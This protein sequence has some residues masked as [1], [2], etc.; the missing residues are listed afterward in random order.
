M[1]PDRGPLPSL[2]QALDQLHATEH[3]YPPEARIAQTRAALTA[4]ERLCRDRSRVDAYF[5]YLG[6][7]D[8]FQPIYGMGH[9][10]HGL[11]VSL[12]Q[13]LMELL[14]AS[15]R[16]LLAFMRREVR[17]QG[18]QYLLERAPQGWLSDQMAARL[19][20]YYLATEPDLA[21]DVLVYGV[22]SRRGVT[23]DEMLRGDDWLH[24]KILE[25]QSCDT[26]YGWWREYLKASRL[27]GLGDG[28][29]FTLDTDAAGRPLDDAALDVQTLAALNHP[30][31]DDPSGIVFIEV[32]PEKQASGQNLV[33]MAD[34]MGGGD[35]RRRPVVLD[36][37]DLEIRDGRVFATKAGCEREIRKGI[38]RIVDVDLTAYVHAREADGQ[39]EVI[40]RFKRIYDAPHVWGD[41]SKH[42]MGFYLINKTT[43]TRLSDLGMSVVARTESLTPERVEAIRREPGRLE[44][45]AIKPLLG[46][47]AKGVIVQPT[48][49][50]LTQAVAHEPMLMQELFHATPVLP[51]INP[52][53]ADPDVRAGVCCEARLLTHGGSPAVAH[54]PHRA[55]TVGGLSRSHYQSA[56]PRRRIKNDRAGRGWYSNMGAILAVK[57]ELGLTSKTDAGVGM[58]PIYWLD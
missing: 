48:L 2:E 44:T 33:F 52:D 43:L 7:R 29:R 56:D 11:P 58:A 32:D 13:Y 10:P 37:R 41:L 17:E 47:S 39:G 15:A 24:A 51:D 23:F 38:S 57:G 12:P 18:P 28:C 22:N 49:T 42:L 19:H 36:P 16:V 50:E 25:A 21:F 3:K 5:G 1:T 14:D 20:D 53:I 45:I 31:A 30:C 55:R 34:A 40:E 9:F 26:Y 54:N 4:N 6:R 46:M 27:V 35:Q 8:M